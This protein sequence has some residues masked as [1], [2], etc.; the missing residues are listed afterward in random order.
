MHSLV[1]H[2]NNA[3][4]VILEANNDTLALPL[5]VIPHLLFMYIMLYLLLMQVKGVIEGQ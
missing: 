1:A 5:P 3:A 4:E 2:S